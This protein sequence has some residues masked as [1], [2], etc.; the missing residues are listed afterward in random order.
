MAFP[1]AL[2]GLADFGSRLQAVASLSD[3]TFLRIEATPGAS[4]D[5]LARGRNAGDPILLV[6]SPR[7]VV[8]R[9]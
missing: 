8:E 9:C 2:L 5:D 1:S 3:R 6:S 7:S 4:V